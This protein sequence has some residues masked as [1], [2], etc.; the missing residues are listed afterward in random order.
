LIVSHAVENG[1][2]NLPLL[3]PTAGG[4]RALRLGPAF[5]YLEYASAKI[6]GNTPPGHA[7]LVLILSILTLPLFYFFC[8]RYFSATIS[9]G[10]L[11]IASSSLYLVLYGRFSWS[12]NILPFLVLLSFY[13]LLRSTAPSENKKDLWFLIFAAA[14]TITT[15]IHFNAFFILP[16]VAII[17]LIFTRPKFKWKTW[18]AAVIIIF[19]IYSP[20]ILSEIKTNG[21]DTGYFFEKIG[22]QSKGSASFWTKLSKD[23]NYT[24]S[25]YFLVDTGLDNINFEKIKYSDSV[26]S[27]PLITATAFILLA[28]EIIVLVYN[29]VKEKERER[30]NFL[31][32]L[33]SWFFISFAYFFFIVNTT[34]FPRFFLILSPLALLLLGLLFEKIRPEK[35]KLLLTAFLAILFLIIFSNGLKIQSYFSQLAEAQTQELKVQTKDVLP[36]TV[37]LTFQQEKKIVDYIA[38]Q[39]QQNNYPVYLQ[40]SHEYGPALWY[41]LEKQ[42]IEFPGKKKNNPAAD[43][44]LGNYFVID[45]FSNHA[46]D[47][48]AFSI[49]E[50]KNFGIL[51]V[52][53]VLPNNAGAAKIIQ[54]DQTAKDVSLQKI[55]IDDLYTWDTLSATKIINPENYPDYELSPPDND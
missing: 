8:R 19:I 6:F 44:N 37:R 20:P 39:Y 32:L 42:E 30:K 18:L 49:L 31:I 34:V 25:E 47:S 2:G 3:G 55:Q 38:G 41:L 22:Q 21:Q 1:I 13:T 4:G 50:T 36:N 26:V 17:F 24:A 53:R 54:D 12:P 35:N 15:Q 9:L 45:Y 28:L 16:P 10:L 40:A 5:Y 29:I 33:G 48:Q 52:Y 14:G 11:A 43:Y 46:P 51:K 7:A 27:N 23:T